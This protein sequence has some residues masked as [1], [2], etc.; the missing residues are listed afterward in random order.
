LMRPARLLRSAIVLKPSTLMAFHRALVTRKYRLLFARRRKP[1][2]KGPSGVPKISNGSCRTSVITRI[3]A[4]SMRH[5]R[6]SLR[7]AQPTA[8]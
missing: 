7:S 2:P 3:T 4:G 5:W 1:G 8:T 6:E